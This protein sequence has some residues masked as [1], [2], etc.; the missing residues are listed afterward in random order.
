M[1]F[2]LSLCYKILAANQ[3]WE[4]KVLHEKNN[5]KHEKQNKTKQNTKNKT[6]HEKQNK[7]RRKRHC[8]RIIYPAQAT[9]N[10]H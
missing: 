10:A 4:L 2:F 8:P 1:M 9:W 5:T 7:K 3:F 6:K